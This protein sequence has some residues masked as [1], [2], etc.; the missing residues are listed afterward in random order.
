MNFVQAL[1]KAFKDSMKEDPNVVVYGLD[2]ADHKRILG[3]TVGLVEEFGENRCFSTPLSEDAMTGVAIGMALNGLRPVHTHIRADFLILGLNQ[4]VNM[5]STLR[6]MN[7]GNIGVPMVVR[8]MIGRGW[9]QGPQHSK[10]L[11]SYFAHIPG[12]KVVMPTSPQDAYSLMREAIKDNDPVVFLEHRWL[13]FADDFVDT[14]KKIP[15]GRS[16]IIKEG[17][18]ITIVSSSWMTVEALKAREIL[19]KHGVSVEIVDLKSIVPMDKETILGSVQKTKRCIVLDYDWTFCGLASEIAYT[20]HKELF[21]D[22]I[23]PVETMGFEHV[24]CPTTRPLENEFYTSAKDIVNKVMSILE[25][26]TIN[27]AN[28]NFYS[29]EVPFKGPF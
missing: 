7:N 11:Q 14:T 13:H 22:L 17:E 6:Y 23:C 5:A 28:E 12:L 16:E 18:D 3:S 4:L 1:N 15:L 2:V 20:V 24:P 25:K 29:H 10:S 27:L 26:D 8:A 9:G 21:G 19:D